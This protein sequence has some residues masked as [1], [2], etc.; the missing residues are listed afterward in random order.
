MTQLYKLSSEQLSPQDHY[1]FGMRAVK[2]ILV[3]A[4]GLKRNS[5][6][7]AEELTLIRACRDSNIPKFVASDIPLFNGILSD[8][9]PGREMPP[10]DYGQL[11]H[12]VVNHIKDRAL[13]AVCRLRMCGG[14]CGARKC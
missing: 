11:E 9:F 14:V 1:D 8:L 5:P 12:L 13:M 6:D 2:S 4:G 3:M 10:V 7:I